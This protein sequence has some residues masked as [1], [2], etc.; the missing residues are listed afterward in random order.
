MLWVNLVELGGDKNLLPRLN[1]LPMLLD[2]EGVVRMPE[3]EKFLTLPS[4]K[5]K[6][7]P[8]LEAQSILT[9]G[10]IKNPVIIL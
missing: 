10:S 6:L 1:H 5:V 3:A 9:L 2:W 7:K 8:L 4:I